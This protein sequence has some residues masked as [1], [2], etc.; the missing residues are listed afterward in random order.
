M[1]NAVH[2]GVP[3]APITIEAHGTSNEVVISVHNEGPAVPEQRRRILFQVVPQE[4][5]DD[6]KDGHLGLGLY[7]VD[8]IVK[9]HGGVV[10][11]ESDPGVG[12]KFVVE[13]PY[14]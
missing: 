10:R 7:I 14:G 1:T 4:R 8:Q 6:A 11:V 12:S 3:S 2:H 13:L 5:A 9:A